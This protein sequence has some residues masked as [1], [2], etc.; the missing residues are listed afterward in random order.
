MKIR[1]FLFT[2]QA[3]KLVIPS[4]AEQWTLMIQPKCLVAPLVVK[5]LLLPPRAALLDGAVILEVVSGILH[6]VVESMG[7]NL[8]QTESGKTPNNSSLTLTIWTKIVGRL[9]NFLHQIWIHILYGASFWID[10]WEVQTMIIWYF[11]T[12]YLNYCRYCVQWE[13]SSGTGLLLHWR[14]CERCVFM[15]S[16]IHYNKVINVQN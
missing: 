11:N 4:L 3:W 1:H 13:I 7:L 16:P 6:T 12:I 14:K 9:C 10:L 2:I 5:E 15:K 8:H